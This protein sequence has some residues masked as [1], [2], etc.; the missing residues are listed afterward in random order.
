MTQRFEPDDLLL[1]QRIS[2]IHVIPD[3]SIALCAV[4]SIDPDARRPDSSLWSF[5]LETGEARRLTH[6]QARDEC[7]RW[8]P[9]GRCIAFLSDRARPGTP[10]IQLMPLDGG[11][12]RPLTR[13]ARGAADI[14]WRPDGRQLLAIGNCTVDPD[15]RAE[16]CDRDDGAEAEAPDDDAPQLCWR[17]PYK[18]DGTGY[19]LDTRAHLFL[20]DA[21]SGEARQ[22][23]R[24]DFEVRHAAWSPDGRRFCYSRTRSEAGREHCTDVWVMDMD[25]D[26]PGKAR[27]LSFEQHN[28]DYP[29]WSP[30]GRWIAFCGALEDGDAQMRLWLI[31]VDQAEVKPLGPQSLEVLPAELTWQRD[32]A[33]IA[34]VQ[35]ERGLQQIAA[36]TVPGGEL[37]C[38][39]GGERQIDRIA[40]NDWLVYSSETADSPLE[41]YCT[42]WRDGEARQLSHF[43]GWWDERRRPEVALRQFDVPDGD[44]GSERIDGWL[45]TPGEAHDGPRPLLVDVHGGPASYVM[46]TYPIHPYWQT[47]CSR[48]WAVLALNAVGSS[49]YGR[50]FSERLR[51]RW[52]ELD[53]PQVLAAVEQLRKQGM[54]DE[55]VAIIGSSYGGYL[56]AYAIGH[57]RE[58]RAAVVCAPVANMES[59]F[60]T[61]DSGYYADAYSTDGEPDEQRELLAR[62]SPM[63]TIEQ[64]RTPT[65]F[66]QGS[67]DERCPRG[68]SEE[69]FVKLRR[70]RRR[71]GGDG[72]LPRWQPPRL[73]HRQALPPPRYPKPHRRLAGALD[74]PAAVRL[75]NHGDLHAASRP[76]RTRGR[77]PQWP[78]ALSASQGAQLPGPAGP[79]SGRHLPRQRPARHRSRRACARAAHDGTRLPGL[80]A[81]ARRLHACRPGRRGR[82][83]G[84]AAI[85]PM[86]GHAARRRLRRRPPP[87]RRA[88]PT[89]AIG[90]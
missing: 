11:E 59:H 61:S 46:L 25:G 47:L 35:V 80:D 14:C 37:R 81:Q 88:L 56:S 43:N 57:S 39:V 20:V 55:R 2:D 66:L 13:L 27:P 8:S 10:Q 65:L 48:G 58:F 5:S 49:S 36:I 33:E 12:A 32:A 1:E 44:G 51:C 28:S 82:W 73:R 54:A 34:F 52:G 42:R 87:A 71:A 40:A 79:R 60:G 19:L 78:H 4:Q 18:L 90:V 70:S 69:L 77:A 29:G 31:D 21:E 15:G 3:S 38:I 9:D 67:D 72:A 16:G 30:D 75:S 23:T 68:Q 41:L 62:L 76:D 17:L 22:L 74:Q 89:V 7:P 50:E 6:G 64:V 24:G 45:L 63:T 84:H 83:P 26:T 85:G 53:L 86:R